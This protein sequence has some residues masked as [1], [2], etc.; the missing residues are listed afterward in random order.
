MPPTSKGNKDNNNNS[1]TPSHITSS[2]PPISAT[3]NVACFISNAYA[4]YHD[5]GRRR[6]YCYK[7]YTTRI[8]PCM[9]PSIYLSMNTARFVVY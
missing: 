2:H 7:L 1:G 6:R 5:E 8:H 9:H 3:M 4:K